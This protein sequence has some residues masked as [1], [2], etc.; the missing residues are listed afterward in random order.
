MSPVEK[1]LGQKVAESRVAAKL[2]QAELAERVGVVTETISRL[3]RGTA[4]PS[5]ARL[6]EIATALDLE[7]PELVA[8]HPRET[9]RD[10][11]IE[12]LLAAVRRRPAEDIEMLADVA[13]RIFEGF[14]AAKRG[15]SS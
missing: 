7:L 10:K 6:E 3:E 8:F 15:R 1:R 5:L 4:V 9:K 2:T 13:R 12:G 11:A 14:P